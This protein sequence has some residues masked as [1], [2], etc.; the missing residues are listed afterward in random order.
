MADEELHRRLQAEAVA[1]DGEAHR[2]LLNGDHTAASAAFSR[3]AETYWASWEVAPPRSFGR[4]VGR[5]K[6]SILGGDGG[7]ERTAADEILSALGDDADAA[8]SPVAAW[9]TALAALSIQDDDRAREAAAVMR[10]GS[11]AFG[12]AAAAVT[13]VADAD[14]D[15]YAAAIDEIVADFAGREEHLTGVPIADTA[16]VL[17]RLA[18]RR[19]IA[20]KPASA[21]VPAD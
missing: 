10:N 3:A 4:L 9:A 12:R 16:V 11:E 19:G 17:E 18:A 15:A 8:G 14:A 21:L 6:A 7:R 5:M 1:H 2:A 20:A 13:A